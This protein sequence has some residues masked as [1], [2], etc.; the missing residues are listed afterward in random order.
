MSAIITGWPDIL[1]CVFDPFDLSMAEIILLLFKN[2]LEKAQSS[3][4]G[5]VS[6]MI[7]LRSY[8]LSRM[9][10]VFNMCLRGIIFATN[11]KMP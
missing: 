5:R 2:Y 1:T 4:I 7:H 3:L 8:I 6:K 10:D 9:I 11:C